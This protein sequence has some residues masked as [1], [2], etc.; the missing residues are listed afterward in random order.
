VVE[1]EQVE[2]AIGRYGQNVRLAAELTGWD[3]N[4]LSVEEAEQKHEQEATGLIQMFMQKLDVDEDVAQVLV[5]EGFTSLEEVAYVPLAEM[6]EI[7]A[8]DE[9]TV[10]ELRSRARDAL[11]TDAIVREEA[12]ESAAADLMSV[13]GMDDDTAALL[14]SKGIQNAEDLADLAVDELVELTA[15]DEERAKALIM[16]ARAPMLAGA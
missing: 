5:E 10:N 2:I 15:M 9:D 7:D 4:I 11:L 12:V 13:D 8:F 3:I 1:P 16:T 14:T 6:L